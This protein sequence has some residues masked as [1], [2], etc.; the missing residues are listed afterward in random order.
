M[1]ALMPT[2]EPE[3]A[4]GKRQRVKNPEGENLF[5]FSLALPFLL[6]VSYPLRS[7]ALALNSTK[8]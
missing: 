2:I 1:F 4:K 8:P 7:L 5:L 6:Q 3:R